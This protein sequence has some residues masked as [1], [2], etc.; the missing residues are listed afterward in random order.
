LCC[1]LQRPM[2]TSISVIRF[3]PLLHSFKSLG[4]DSSAHATLLLRRRFSFA[5]IHH[6]KRENNL[7]SAVVKQHKLRMDLVWK[8]AISGEGKTI[9]L[10]TARKEGFY[11]CCASLLFCCDAFKYICSQLTTITN[12]NLINHNHNYI[13][14]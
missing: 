8:A 9:K 6:N 13:P 2:L 5:Q 14:L 3:F 4:F 7:S 1:V 10:Q 11:L 12:R